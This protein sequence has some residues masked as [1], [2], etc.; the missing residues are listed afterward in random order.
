MNKT[1]KLVLVAI[2]GALAV[3]FSILRLQ[4]PF[5]PLPYLKL[6]FAELPVTLALFLCGFRYAVIAEIL[7]FLGLLARGSQPIDA[8]M[9]LVA[10]LS[11]LVGLAAPSSSF[12][13]R[14][15]SAAVLRSLVMSMMNYVYFY[16]LFPNFLSYALKLAGS[17]EALF[18]LTAIFNIVHVAVS[19][20]LAWAVYKEVEKRR[21]LF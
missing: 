18:I 10:V 6:D 5:L 13:V 16:I 9:K 12:L 8:S 21:I 20:G 3:A 7:H 14:L 11:M 4:L 1:R 17:I 15:V 19:A 2:L